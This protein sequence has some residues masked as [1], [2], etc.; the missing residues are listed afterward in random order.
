MKD[1]HRV[2][3]LLRTIIYGEVSLMIE[4]VMKLDMILIR[5]LSTFGEGHAAVESGI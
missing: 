3:R 5:I 1:I 2:M 4:R